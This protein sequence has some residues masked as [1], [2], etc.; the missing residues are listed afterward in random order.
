MRNTE[1]GLVYYAAIAENRP[2]ITLQK[3]VNIH[4]LRKPFSEE[5][6]KLHSEIYKKGLTSMIE[7]DAACQERFEIVDM[8]RD[9]GNFTMKIYNMVVAEE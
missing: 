3:M 8:Q 7:E 1:T 9:N 6:F 5:D 4:S 2:L